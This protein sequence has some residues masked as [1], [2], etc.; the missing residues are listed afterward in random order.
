MLYQYRTHSDINVKEL[1]QKVDDE[2]QESPL[3]NNQPIF[4]P[5]DKSYITQLDAA[6][7]PLYSELEMYVSSETIKYEDPGDY[8]DCMKYIG[9]IFQ[10]VDDGN[11]YLTVPF[12]QNNAYVCNSFITALSLIVKHTHYI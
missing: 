9:S 12:P 10:F 7:Y 1:E 6:G 8:A 2:Q 3:F 4:Q 5:H 11:S